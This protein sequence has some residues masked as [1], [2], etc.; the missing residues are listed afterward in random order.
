MWYE[1]NMKQSR[2]LASQ[3]DLCIFL[4]ALQFSPGLHNSTLENVHAA[5]Q[6]LFSKK[7]L[8]SPV[9]FFL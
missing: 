6:M 8:F 3:V 7:Y 5:S 2:E 1:P 9:R 4:P